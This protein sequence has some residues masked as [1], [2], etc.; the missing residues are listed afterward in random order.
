MGTPMTGGANTENGEVGRGT[1]I[2]SARTTVRAR[3]IP[4]TGLAAATMIRA[5]TR[6]ATITDAGPSRI[7]TT[8]ATA[9][10]GVGGAAGASPAPRHATLGVQAIPSSSRD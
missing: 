5:T 10:P 9:G 7:R 1:P 3:A 6:G 2:A 4:G 8:R